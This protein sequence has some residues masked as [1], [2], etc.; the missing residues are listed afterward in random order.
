MFAC[1][2]VCSCSKSNVAPTDREAAE[3]INETNDENA[4]CSS[5]IELTSA[6]DGKCK[7]YI[8]KRAGAD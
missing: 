6:A 1:L 4:I 2:C 5:L 3:I 8:I 7:I